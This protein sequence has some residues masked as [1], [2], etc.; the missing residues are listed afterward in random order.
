MASICK[1]LGSTM[2]WLSITLLA[3]CSRS[4]PSTVTIEMRTV[5]RINGCHVSLDLIRYFEDGSPMGD[6]RFVCDVSESA[7]KEKKWWGDQPQPLMSSLAVN[8]CM[9]LKKTW[10]CVESI[11]PGKSATLK[12]TFR[13]ID[14]DVTLIE[15]IK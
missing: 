6:V 9:R 2:L 8:D 14:S 1:L 10:Y 12:A 15:R 11:E 13:T 4:E 3:S 5:E 7:L